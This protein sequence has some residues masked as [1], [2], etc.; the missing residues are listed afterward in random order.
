MEIIFKSLNTINFK[1]HKELKIV[2][3]DVN[4]ISGKNGAGKSSVGEVITWGLYG[5]DTLGT[6]L[7]P[8]PIGTDLETKVELLIQVDGN[9]Y[10]LGRTQKK[11]A[12][13]YIN[14]VP[15][16]ATKFNEFVESLFDK[17]LFLSLFT[18]GYF[19]TQHWQDQRNQLLQYVKEPLNKEVLAVLNEVKRGY[20]EE[21]LKKYSLDDLEKIHRDR[22]NKHDKAYER[23]AERVLT[24]E[25]QLKQLESIAFINPDEVQKKIA[26]IQEELTAIDDKHFNLRNQNGERTKIE[27]QID[28]LKS[29]IIQQKKVVEGIKNESI[30][31]S[32]STCGQALDE[33]SLQKVKE[34]RQQRFNTEVVKGQE[35][36]QEFQK[37]T[38][39][40]KALPEQVSIDPNEREKAMELHDQIYKLKAQLNNGDRLGKLKTDIAEANANKETIRIERNESQGII[41]AIKDFRTKRSEMMV[42]K[43]DNLFTNISV[44]LYET[45]K[46]GDQK[47][48]FEIEMDGKPYSKLSTAEKIKAGL[49]LIEVL[50]QQSEVI[51][52]TFVDNAES[53]LNFTAPIGQLVVARVVDE[54][55]NIKTKSL[56]GGE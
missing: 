56:K 27:T 39:Q 7:D 55:F 26:T 34:N 9:Q 8:K 47:A 43:V 4:S 22:F 20:L 36:Y 37:F 23:A 31:E 41:E 25:E 15:E 30:K 53:I 24:L 17:N 28:S 16:K 19:F 52:P 29:Q 2:F 1:N 6:K 33:D 51:A 49:E 12:K 44:R 32:C 38:E 10:L 45:L 14:E 18:P 5:T 48:T 3:D 54:D 35:L 46:N 42:K 11:T 40:L 50:S 21:N 13:F